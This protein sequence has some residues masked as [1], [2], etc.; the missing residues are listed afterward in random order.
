M[1]DDIESYILVI[2]LIGNTKYA[3]VITVVR[4]GQ[5]SLLFLMETDNFTQ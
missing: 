1:I 4:Y 3:D 2:N 5:G